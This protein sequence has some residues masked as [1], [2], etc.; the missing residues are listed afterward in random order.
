MGQGTV[1]TQTDSDQRDQ[2]HG[3]WRRETPLLGS[4]RGSGFELLEYFLSPAQG[5][6]HICANVL[7]S[8][9]VLKLRLMNDPQ[10]LFSRSTEDQRTACGMKLF[11]DFLQ[12]KEASCVDGG[13]VAQAQ[14]HHW[15]QF[16]NIFSDDGNLIGGTE[17]KWP[18][19]AEDGRVIRNVLVLK[20]VY[21]AIFDIVI[22]DLRYS[23]CT[24]HAA[25]E[26]QRSQYHPGLDRN[27]KISKHRQRESHEPHTDIRFGKFQQLGNFAP[28]THVVG[29]DDQNPG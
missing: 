14:D 21:T 10:R 2:R 29:H 7:V 16:V 5:M 12:G 4:C 26:Q 17:Q 27:C 13:H 11:C 25:D 24:R 6:L 28:L 23:S 19:N 18:V 8:N 1:A 15:R 22:R 20:D 3:G 9:H